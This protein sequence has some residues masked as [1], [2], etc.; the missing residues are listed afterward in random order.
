MIFKYQ[1]EL[2]RFFIKCPPETCKPTNVSAFRWIFEQ[3]EDERNFKPL[4]FKNP[5]RI[6][7]FDDVEKCQALGLSMFDSEK[8]AIKQFN[9]LKTRL[10][11]TAYQV[12]G[13]NL[14]LGQLVPDDGAASDPDPK[15]HFTIHPSETCTFESSFQIVATL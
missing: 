1:A 12:L 14:A 6:N 9:F 8:N 2:N 5:Q 4:Y 11:E 13:T 3:L 15:G 10:G 7:S